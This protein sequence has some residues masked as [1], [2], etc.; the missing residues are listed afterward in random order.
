[1]LYDMNREM[2]WCQIAGNAFIENSSKRLSLFGL[3]RVSLYMRGTLL[4]FHTM[5]RQKLQYMAL[6]KDCFSV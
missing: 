4:H 2:R 3:P 6:F 5:L 1:Y